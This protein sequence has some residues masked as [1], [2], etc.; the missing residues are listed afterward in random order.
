MSAQ[1]GGE[2]EPLIHSRTPLYLVIGEADEYYS[3]EPVGEAYETF[4]D[5]YEKE[6][7]SADEINEVLVLDVKEQNY[8]NK[9]G[10]LNQHGG[11]LIAHDKEIMSWL[12][13]K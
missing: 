5:S 8:Y 10:T 4:R 1:W 12:F 9:R 13:S 3:S 11:G 6:G 2:Y 7:F